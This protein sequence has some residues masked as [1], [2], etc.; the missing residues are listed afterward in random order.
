MR[1]KFRSQGNRNLDQPNK[2][3]RESKLFVYLTAIYIITWYLQ[4]GLRVDILGTI[5]F[6]FLLGLFLSITA[7]TKLM[8][9]RGA[10]PLKT[11]VIFFYFIILF[12]TIFSYDHSAS[13]D[14]FYQRV[15]K[16]SMLA[17]F[18]SAFVRTEWALKIV[19]GA[20]LLAMLKM[21]QEGFV[22]WLGGGLVWQNQGVM[23][24]H[25]STPS[26]RHPN[27]FSGMAVGCLPFIYFLFP[28]VKK[29]WQ[30]ILLLIL[31]GFSLTII[32]FTASRTGYV[33]TGLL[34]VYAII[35]LKGKSKKIALITLF[36]GFP[37]IFSLAPSEYLDRLQSI[38]TLE[39]AEGSSA[40]ARITI[41]KDA[42]YIAITKPWGVGVSAFPTVRLDSFGRSQ[43]THNL[44]LE[45][46]TNLSIV[47]FISFIWLIK[48]IIETNIITQNELRNIDRDDAKF[49]VAIS[50]AIVGFVI[51]RLFLG[52]FGM[53]TYEIYWWFA[54]GLTISVYR[55]KVFILGSC[56]P[57]KPTPLTER[58][59]RMN[60]RKNSHLNA[61][62]RS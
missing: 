60:V 11:P 18:L 13:W 3:S 35:K 28:V 43:D 30:K 52:L 48:K 14:T 42:L 12:Y 5:R 24:L 34:V 10:T 32:V 41:L 19:V 16:F 23:R 17:L 62:N 50:K 38:Y 9:E 26:Y 6:E 4:L 29:Y 27:S 55:T 39:E 21:G 2:T 20:F 44:Y 33:A 59:M 22:G 37:V 40:N 61:G 15:F 45:L 53:D 31:L 46:I 58:G 36:V 47:G 51:A 54:I 1:Q 7:V 56:A 57:H 8:S 49:V 25:G